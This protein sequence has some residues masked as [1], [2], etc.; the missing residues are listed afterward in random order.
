MVRNVRG[1][2]EC[3]DDATEAIYTF[4]VDLDEDKEGLL[5]YQSR[6]ADS[7]DKPETADRPEHPGFGTS[8]LE[9]NPTEAVTFR[10]KGALGEG[11]LA[12]TGELDGFQ[13][14]ARVQRPDGK[15][16][17]GS[18]NLKLRVLGAESDQVFVR[19]TDCEPTG[20]NWDEP[21]I[22]IN[23]TADNGSHVYLNGELIGSTFDWRN[24]L[25][26]RL[27]MLS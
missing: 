21:P 15:K 8:D 9:G 2:V 11:T 7:A 12:L 22:G 27:M 16:L 6:A 4:R 23:F 20:R 25:I 13:I 5:A 3:A 10:G 19:E 24:P 1:S 17:L 18:E 14:Q 26:S